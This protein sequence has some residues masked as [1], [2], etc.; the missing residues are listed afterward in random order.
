MKTIAFAPGIAFESDCIYTA[1]REVY[2]IYPGDTEQISHYWWSTR[3]DAPRAAF[4][5]RGLKNVTI[6]LGGAKLMFHG[7]ILPFAIYN[8]ENVSFKN[9]SIDRE[10]FRDFRREGY[11]R[12]AERYERRKFG[13]IIIADV[14]IANYCK[15]MVEPC[16]AVGSLA[17]HVHAVFARKTGGTGK[18]IAIFVVIGERPRAYGTST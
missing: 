4:I 3:G 8:C 5:L 16:E 2:D 7:R 15:L 1:D 11:G 12:A 17:V 10:N 18:H 9:F 6:D 14:Q 13:H